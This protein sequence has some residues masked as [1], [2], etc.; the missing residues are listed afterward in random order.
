MH[1]GRDLDG[2]IFVGQQ[3]QFYLIGPKRKYMVPLQMS[4]CVVGFET[5]LY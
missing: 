5:P 4:I 2:L 1:E 3:Y